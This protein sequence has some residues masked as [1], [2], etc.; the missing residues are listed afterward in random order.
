VARDIGPG[1][2]PAARPVGRPARSSEP[3][4]PGAWPQWGRDPGHTGAAPVGGQPLA[5]ILADIVSDPFTAAETAERDGD[6]FVHYAAPLIE[7]SDL[8][9]EFKSGAYVACDSPTSGARCPARPESARL[10]APVF[11]RMPR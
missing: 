4:S 1:P 7:G 6:L 5:A 11:S 9:V 2:R 8:Y 10:R 3:R